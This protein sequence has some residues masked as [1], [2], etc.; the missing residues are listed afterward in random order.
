MTRVQGIK[1]TFAMLCISVLFVMAAHAAESSEATK[2]ADATQVVSDIMNAPDFEIPQAVLKDASGIAVIPGVVKAGF[3]IGGRYG[4]G[5]LTVMR[6][7]GAWSDPVFIS[8]TGG[9]F[10][11]QFGVQS[12]DV[13]L[14]FKT[15]RS[16]EAISKGKFTLGGDGSIAAGPVGR[17]ASAGTD[18]TLQAEIYSYSRNRGLF[19]GLSLEGSALQIEDAENAAFYGKPGISAA[20]IME[21]KVPKTPAEVTAFREGIQKLTREHKK[22]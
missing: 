4:K 15:R 8:I 9:S 12:T 10:G 18:I 2:M 20:D 1:A 3:W 16:I 14:V 13:V 7:S 22:E 5:V 19:I 17:N 11:W 6:S 21:D